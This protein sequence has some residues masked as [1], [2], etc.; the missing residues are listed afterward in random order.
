M[1]E[2]SKYC[3]GRDRKGE[4]C[5]KRIRCLIYKEEIPIGETYWESPK[6]VEACESFMR[7]KRKRIFRK[8]SNSTIVNALGILFY[9]FIRT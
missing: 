7:N 8:I 4:L 3:T 5:S 9:G 2:E 1:I 6:T